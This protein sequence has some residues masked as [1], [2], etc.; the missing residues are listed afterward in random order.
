MKNDVEE[1]ESVN[2]QCSRNRVWSETYFQPPRLSSDVLSTWNLGWAIFSLNLLIWAPGFGSQRNSKKLLNVVVLV[3]WLVHNT[4]FFAILSILRVDYQSGQPTDQWTNG[5]TDLVAC[6]RL[7]AI[8][9]VLT[10]LSDLWESMRLTNFS[11]NLFW[12]L[13]HTGQQI[14]LNIEYWILSYIFFN[15]HSWIFAFVI[16]HVQDR[17]HEIDWLSTRH[18][19]HHFWY[20]RCPSCVRRFWPSWL[21]LWCHQCLGELSNGKPGTKAPRL[22]K[23]RSLTHKRC[24]HVPE[25]RESAWCIACS[26]KSLD[27]LPSTTKTAQWMVISSSATEAHSSMCNAERWPS[28][29]WHLDLQNAPTLNKFFSPMD[30][31]LSMIQ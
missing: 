4:D 28:N 31:R 6:T 13:W 18:S 9:L 24:C 16:I 1:A 20:Q 10:L 26:S 25:R 7:M 27:M 11:V 14:G 15:C 29:F 2:T 22:P 17:H 8:D 12:L 30:P 23:K 3:S 5:P 21:Q 19:W